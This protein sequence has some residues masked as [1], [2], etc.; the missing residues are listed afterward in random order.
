MY[1][2]VHGKKFL[3]LNISKLSKALYRHIYKDNIQSRVRQDV[4]TTRNEI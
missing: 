1:I 3:Y 4:E 2:Y